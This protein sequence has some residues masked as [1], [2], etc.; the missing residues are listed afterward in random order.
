MPKSP[1]QFFKDLSK[2][3]DAAAKASKQT[4]THWQQI[5][6]KVAKATSQLDHGFVKALTTF[7]GFAPL[8]KS[9]GLALSDAF[10]GTRRHVDHIRAQWFETARAFRQAKTSA[11]ADAA[12]DRLK[13]LKTELKASRVLT[14]E[15]GDIITS[16]WAIAAGAFVGQMVIAFRYSHQMQD[17]LKQANSDYATRARLMNEISQVQAATG[18]EMA[19][20][21]KGAAALVN[22]GYDLRGN[23]KDTLET[24]VK[25]EEGLGV[26]YDLSAQMAVAVRRI[27]GDFRAVADSV[28]RIKADT[29][30][31]ADE[32]TRFATQ[33]S[34]AVMMLR[35]GSGGLIANTSDYISRMAAALKEL[36]GSGDD[37][38]KMMTDFTKESGM[39]GA[40]TLGAT[41]DFLSNPAQA[42]KVTERFVNYVN[43][44][45]AGT[46]GY[47]RMATIQ[48]LAEQF[49]TSADVIANASEM[50]KRYNETQQKGT[51]LNEQW[52]QQTAE[53]GKT[54][55]KIGNSLAAII[56]Q[57]L[58]PVIRWLNPIL[59]KLAEVIQ[60]VSK[61]SGALYIGIGALSLSAIGAAITIGRL[62]ASLWKFAAT[63][64]LLGN[65]TGA[66]GAGGAAATG[67]RGV[68]M[69]WLPRIG[70]L[71]TRILVPIALIA[72]A[73]VG[74]WMAG[75]WLDK[76]ITKYFG[77]K[78]LGETIAEVFGKKDAFRAQ[79]M[80][81]TSGGM[82]RN[83]ILQQ[84]SAMAMSGKSAE[85][86]QKFILKS[87]S[88]MK[89]LHGDALTKERREKILTG[90]I[91]DAGLEITRQRV[92][93]GYA[94]QLTESTAEDR[95]KDAQMIELYKA[96]ANNTALQNELLKRAE[97]KHDNIEEV[98]RRDREEMQGEQ[99]LIRQS[100]DS[101][102]R[103]NNIPSGV[104][105][106]PTHGK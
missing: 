77:G 69:S 4:D 29:A 27:G 5:G 40:A 53:L 104:F 6:E 49:N 82:T 64:G 95:A 38:V 60:W 70:S 17:V 45:L 106:M 72:G 34:Q 61:S 78:S 84:V 103:V 86:I 54:M 22:Y 10:L 31:S 63:S 21:G 67:L 52:R 102:S 26:S 81:Y 28:A 94:R 48:L 13:Q 43:Q 101:Q 88:S 90:F 92:R 65:F 98:K 79:Q 91:Q 19:D 62:T 83:D 14:K 16:K 9:S 32:A 89:G 25:M 11:D 59:E 47:Q 56:Q 74:G 36:T 7:T 105:F 66:S 100:I 50:M 97:A 57:T 1:D 93:M 39:M 73:A 8:L 68:V 55:S 2:A 41:P 3:M 18:N 96:I 85:E 46:S 33:I 58:V 87:A 76:K 35:P 12:L 42:K 51:S 20:M 99:R 80:A 71:L 15:I 23:F 30:L 37:F 24:M 44:Q 75:S